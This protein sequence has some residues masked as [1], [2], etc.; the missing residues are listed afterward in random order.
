MLGNVS[1]LAPSPFPSAGT[2]P[3]EVCPA[4]TH[5]PCTQRL[6]APTSSLKHCNPLPCLCQPSA[7]PPPPLGVSG[8]LWASP[9][10]IHALLRFQLLSLLVSSKHTLCPV[11]R[12][13]DNT[14]PLFARSPGPCVLCS[15]SPAQF[16]RLHLAPANLSVPCC[17]LAC[18]CTTDSLPPVPAQPVLSKRKSW[19]WHLCTGL[20][21][22]PC[23]RKSPCFLAS[24]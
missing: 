2:P 14:R 20:S 21:E 19:R 17:A 10:S 5:S 18:T 13:N 22:D 8:S 1:S 23:L 12:Q 24:W 7:G 9:H 15:S 11:P 4:I 3:S 6:P 16:L